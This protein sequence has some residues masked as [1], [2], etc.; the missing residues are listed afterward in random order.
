M[1]LISQLN[2]KLKSLTKFYVRYLVDK[3]VSS[4]LHNIKSPGHIKLLEVGPKPTIW[5]EPFKD[6]ITVVS[7]D[8]DSDSQA[9]F[10]MDVCNMKEF[11]N[12][13]F[14]LVLMVE[15]LEH[16]H[17]PS[18]AINE[19]YRVLKPGG[20]LLLTTPFLFPIHDAPNDFFRF[21]KFGLKKILNMFDQISVEP[22]DYFFVSIWI[23]ISRLHM[24]ESKVKQLLGY[25]IYI[26]FLPLLPLCILLDFITRFDSYSSRYLAIGRKL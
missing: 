1:H 2:I 25:L 12:E 20:Q 14:D 11:D 17:N 18:L 19:I 24:N 8:V 5:Y 22:F 4:F 9:D 15:V 13:S 21:T 7:I 23:L 6:K 26:L 10:I 3:H 16:V